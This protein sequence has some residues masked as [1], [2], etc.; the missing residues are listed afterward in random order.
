MYS[1][2]ITISQTIIGSNSVYS[3]CKQFYVL[4]GELLIQGNR[5][6]GL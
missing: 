3:I 5:G 4:N 1:K 2:S 6:Y